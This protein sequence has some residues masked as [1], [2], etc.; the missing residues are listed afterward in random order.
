M[1]ACAGSNVNRLSATP[2]PILS[3]ALRANCRSKVDPG[4]GPDLAI[5]SDA[6]QRALQAWGLPIPDDQ[7][8]Q[9]L[10]LYAE[11]LQLW[12]SK[13]NLT[14][15]RD[16]DGILHRHLMEGAFAASLV[17]PDAGTVLDFGS[18]AGIPGI[19][20]A[21]VRPALKVTLADANSKKAA[22]LR[23]V[24]RQ[25]ELPLT[26]HTQRVTHRI[27][28]AGFDLVTMRAVDRLGSA[29][30]SASLQLAPGGHLMFLVSESQGESVPGDVDRIVGNELAW[31][32]HLI[33]GIRRGLVLI[34]EPV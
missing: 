31:K 18:G 19:P 25:I 1:V 17:P 34:G 33:P 27:N 8:L 20:I 7:A 2:S 32:R 4:T 14:A 15:I 23:E 10:V 5:T 21:I 16:D 22:F 11:L 28:E 6:I 26:V 9:R 3:A 12:N 13:L 29:L 30:L 24:A